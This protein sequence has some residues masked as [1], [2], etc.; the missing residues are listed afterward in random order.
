M[1]L[2]TDGGEMSDERPLDLDALRRGDANEFARLVRQHAALVAGACQAIGLTGS[3]ADDASAIAFASVYRSL[4]AFEE[5]SKLSTWVY[6]IA[7][8]QALNFRE[9]RGRSRR[10]EMSMHG[11]DDRTIDPADSK[12]AQP[13]VIA[14]KAEQ[15]ERLW[16]VVNDLEPRQAMA[17]ELFY[18]R[19]MDLV[20]IAEVMACPVNTVKTHLSRARQKLR[21]LLEPQGIM[22]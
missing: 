20:G 21:A 22:S 12:Q 17:V 18:R 2:A 6:R 1:A 9:R 13:D 3:D 7:L 8:R 4:P 11:A 10:H 19:G 5:R 14:E 16:R 15:K